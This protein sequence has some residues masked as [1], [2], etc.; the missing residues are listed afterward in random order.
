MPI[1]PDKTIPKED[2]D[3]P[4]YDLNAKPDTKDYGPYMEVVGE[5]GAVNKTTGEFIKL[6]ITVVNVDDN[7][8]AMLKSMLVNSHV[9]TRTYFQRKNITLPPIDEK[10]YT[11][12]HDN[13]T[14]IR[15]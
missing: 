3:N 7:K 1:D 9:A 13:F 8:W 12:A 11:Y 10:E 4:D 15:A 6:G 14:K 2:E 5:E